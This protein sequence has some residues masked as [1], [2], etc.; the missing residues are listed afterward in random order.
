MGKV[1]HVLSQ[2]D[3]S[4]E[5]RGFL[6][7]SMMIEFE[8]SA[9]LAFDA[10]EGGMGCLR[11]RRRDLGENANVWV[12][13]PTAFRRFFA[14]L[15]RSAGKDAF[16]RATKAETAKVMDSLLT[17]VLHGS[18]PDDV[19]AAFKKESST[20][21]IVSDLVKP[22]VSYPGSN[23][24]A[25][26]HSPQGRVLTKYHASHG[27]PA[28]GASASLEALI[29]TMRGQ[30]ANR[31]STGRPYAFV[32]RGANFA[33]DRFAIKPAARCHLFNLLPNH[34]SFR[35]AVSSR[36]DARAWVKSHTRLDSRQ[37]RLEPPLDR[38]LQAAAHLPHHLG[39][40][41]RNRVMAICRNSQANP[42]DTYRLVEVTAVFRSAIKAIGDK[43]LRL[44]VRD[45]VE[46]ELSEV[47]Q[48]PMI[49]FADTGHGRDNEPILLAVGRG[50]LSGKLG[51][52]EVKEVMTREGPRII[53]RRRERSW[54]GSGCGL[55]I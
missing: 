35:S 53:Q 44:R 11:I 22:W 54:H 9:W 7:H 6:L 24:V 50:V 8:K 28:S 16:P 23:G 49:V 32:M 4:S 34:N 42:P 18:F 13:D 48:T 39:E 37:S 25:I 27:W 36:L 21:S 20:R 26:R 14:E 51:Y 40:S 17:Y 30:K 33:G 3:C 10:T 31:N 1:G 55:S 47:L 46:N 45:A 2:V 5:I 38:L 43:S 19:A 41:V 15:L 52:W 12:D 29:Q